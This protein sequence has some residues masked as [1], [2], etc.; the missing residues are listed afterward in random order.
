MSGARSAACPGP[1][2]ALTV[3][4]TSGK[5][6]PVDAMT[7]MKEEH[8][9]IE[10]GLRALETW[11]RGV[12][13]DNADDRENLGRFAAFF[14]EYANAC[15]QGKE[16]ALLFAIVGDGDLSPDRELISILLAEN[17]QARWLVHILTK[18]A[19][20]PEMWTP[21]DV[22][23]IGDV[24]RTYAALMR[25][26]IRKEESMLFPLIGSRSSC[27]TRF[28]ISRRVERLDD[29]KTDVG[30]QQRLHDLAESLITA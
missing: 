21:R 23:R 6:I 16:E 24:V 1:T 30:A 3:R 20:G 18:M 29:L 15:H 19:R 9:V 8:R 26:H 17:D 13:A 5:I 7:T 11:V 2:L 22:R 4:S 10:Q 12:H 14:Q 28:E 27:Q 25:E